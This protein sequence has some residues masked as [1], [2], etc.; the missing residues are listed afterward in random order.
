MKCTMRA[1]VALGVGYLLGRRHKLRTAT[2]MAV[3]AAA[4]GTSVGRT[5]LRRGAQEFVNSRVLDKVS[6]QVGEIVDAVRGDLLDAAMAA[7]SAEVTSKIDAL[8]DSLQDRAERLRN[9][10]ATV[11]EGAGGAAGA[12]RDTVR[13][14]AGAAAEAARDTAAGAAG[15]ASGAASGATRR[16]LRRGRDSESRHD[17]REDKRPEAPEREARYAGHGDREAEG[18]RRR[19]AEPARTARER[20]PRQR[21]SDDQPQRRARNVERGR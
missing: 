2:V 21:S 11:A 14:T 10:G 9:P 20:V 6:P 1:A 15:A 12:A 3:A 4:G 17:E 5:A 18:G 16:L 13:A 7:A 8:S 19:R